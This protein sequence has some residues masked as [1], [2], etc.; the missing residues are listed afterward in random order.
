MYD[1][2]LISKRDTG[3]L[4]EMMERIHVGTIGSNAQYMEEKTMRFLN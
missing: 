3:C 2:K 1:F 4:R